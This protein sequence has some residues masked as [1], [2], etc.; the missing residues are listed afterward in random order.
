MLS[1]LQENMPKHF[2]KYIEPFF[3]GGALFFSGDFSN[4]VISDSNTE[5][6]NLYKVVATDVEELIQKLSHI[7]TIRRS[8]IKY[9]H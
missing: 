6:I 2:N 9:V 8:F 7:A 4:A 5:L 3:G 1:I